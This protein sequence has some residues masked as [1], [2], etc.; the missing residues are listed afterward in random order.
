VCAA[1]GK[2]FDGQTV[3]NAAARKEWQ[4]MTEEA[5]EEWKLSYGSYVAGAPETEQR[6]VSTPK[7]SKQPAATSPLSTE[8]QCK[9][10][11]EELE[12]P[13]PLHSTRVDSLEA[14]HKRWRSVKA[15]LQKHPSPKDYAKTNAQTMHLLY[16]DVLH[17]M[18]A[19]HLP[20]NALQVEDKLQA[21]H[22][23]RLKLPRVKEFM[24]NCRQEK[25]NE[26]WVA[27]TF[28]PGRYGCG[29][30]TVPQKKDLLRHVH[31]MSLS[32]MSLF[33]AEIKRSMFKLVLY[34]QG[35]I[36][37]EDPDIPW[38]LFDKM[39]STIQTV[40]K[41]WRSWVRE[42]YPA[43]LGLVNKRIKARSSAQASAINPASIRE[44][45]D[46]LDT[47][48]KPF[49]AVK[50]KVSMRAWADVWPGARIVP[51]DEGSITTSSFVHFLAEFGAWIRND[52]Q[53]PK[54][55]QV[56]LLLDSGGGS[57]IHISA[58]ASLVAE[59]FAIRLWFFAANTTAAF[60]SLDQ[61]CN[62]AAEARFHKLVASGHDMSPLGALHAARDVWDHS[63]CSPLIERGYK[64]TGIVAKSA[65]Q[66][67]TLLVDRAPELM[68]SKVPKKEVALETAEAASLLPG[69]YTIP[70]RTEAGR[71]SEAL[72]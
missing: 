42:N 30:L 4:A 64:K 72:Y 67:N 48:L 61:D 69:A 53:L 32:N 19:G 6:D 51:S 29:L 12:G 60:C 16:L 52:L 33:P 21:Y 66:R 24:S 5:R 2:N 57:Q 49:V 10:M 17:L 35:Q 47:V 59:H 43:R 22:I 8:K 58:D 37:L 50:G 71:K 15:D 9:R 20:D 25:R 34:N 70:N 54:E 65:L 23:N 1:V 38:Q 31:A 14:F 39:S 44:H 40:Y 55:R 63:Y 3:E 56:L 41:D 46:Q 7:R 28:Q 62:A 26:N 36:G 11:P 13:Q 27:D 45:F 68:R 18:E